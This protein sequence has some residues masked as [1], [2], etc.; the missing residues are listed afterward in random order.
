MIDVLVVGAGSAGCV[1]A[2]RLS[3]KGLSVCVVEAGPDLR[4]ATTPASITGESFFDALAEPGLIH[5]DLEAR[6]VD[7][8]APRPYLRGR[9]VGGSSAVNAM[10][11]LWGEMDDYDS[12]ERD[13]GCVGWGWRDVER[14]FRRIEVPLRRAEPEGPGSVAGSLVEACIMSG[15]ALHRGPFPLA[16]I[17]ADA[18][19]AMLTRDANGRRVTAADAYLERARERGNVVVRTDVAVDRVVVEGGRAV[20]VLLVDGTEIGAREV[21]LCAGA[22]HSP[23]ILLRSGIDRPGIGRGLQDHPSVPVT[24]GL[25]HERDPHSLAVSAIT[26]F[27]SGRH[28]ADLQLLP[29]N[30]LGPDALGYGSISVALMKVSSRGSVRLNPNDPL[31]EPIVDFDLLSRD[32]DVES[33]TVGV[34]VLLELLESPSLASL[35]RGFFVDDR[36]TALAE[37]AGSPDSVRAWMRE[38]TGDYVHAAGTCAMGD[39][40]SESTVVDSD[41]RVIGV[42]GLRVCDASIFPS[43]PRANTHFPVMMAAEMVAGRW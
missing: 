4:S 27:S 17:P 23:T 1:L 9:G 33:L 38:A 19:P 16:G 6:R 30:H 10:V 8:Q 35:A 12:W 3:S 24:V 14:C 22:I 25:Q 41:A 40:R 15:W 34:G 28:D 37:I 21:V 2:D 13:F 11:G 32:E 42:A 43:L 31:A 20:G 26:R 7:G 5:R 18:G 29:I 36:G 39:P